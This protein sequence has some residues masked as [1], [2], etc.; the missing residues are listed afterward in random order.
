MNVAVTVLAADIATVQLV[1]EVESQPAQD[2]K[3][4]PEAAA[5]VSVTLVPDV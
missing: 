2:V 1:P 4:E 3:L 5:A